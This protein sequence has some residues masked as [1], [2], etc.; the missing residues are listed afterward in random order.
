VETRTVN[1]L[2]WRGR[3]F[4]VLPNQKISDPIGKMLFKRVAESGDIYLDILKRN[5][6]LNFL[7]FYIPEISTYHLLCMFLLRDYPP[8]CCLYSVPFTHC[9]ARFDRV[10]TVIVFNICEYCRCRYS[11]QRSC[12]FFIFI[13]EVSN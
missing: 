4:E 3:G 9:S 13:T 10:L 7:L 6:I 5:R 8:I 12:D 2:T 11:S 1:T